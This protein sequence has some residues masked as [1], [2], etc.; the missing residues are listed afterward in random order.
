MNKG[1]QFDIPILF[2]I[3]RRK[4]T[5][6]QVIDAISK[7]KPRKL[8]ISQDGPRTE[9]EVNQIEQTR[10]AVL[11]KINWDCQ[12]TVWTHERNLGLKKH[13]PEAFDKF[14]EKE[15]YG[16]YLEDDTLPSEDFFYFQKELLEKYKNDSRI[17]SV[18][19]TNFYPE[20]TKSN[21]SY[22]LTK[23]GDIWGF[24]LWRRSWKLYNS[25]LADFDSLSKTSKYDSYFFN[26][27]YKYYLETFWKAII[28]RRLNSWAM[29]VIYAAVKNNMFFISPSVN[30]VNNI[31]VN[32]SASNISLQ[33]YHRMYGNPFPLKYPDV[34]TYDKANDVKYFDSMLSGGWARLLLIK[35]YL[36]FPNKFKILLGNFINKILPRN[37]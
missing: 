12:L 4:D 9:A 32:R 10:K 20:V 23:I 29:Q 19:G 24:G 33:T 16:I 7:V 26:R 15:E 8:Y 36:S 30:M 6:L 25:N 34:L 18:N 28:A 1:N 3:F 5:A 22:Y 2:I 35:V 37:G 27:R 14:F 13:I 31:G 17:F 11:A 21:G